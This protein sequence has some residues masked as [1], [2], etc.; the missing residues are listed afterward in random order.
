MHNR[1]AICTICAIIFVYG[2]AGANNMKEKLLLMENILNN[3]G[4]KMKLYDEAMS[5]IKQDDT[6]FQSKI[7]PGFDLHRLYEFL[8]SIEP[9]RL[10][11]TEDHLSCHYCFFRLYVNSS[12]GGG[13]GNYNI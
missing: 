8:R 1:A 6:G 11:F 10:Y 3:F 9:G 4:V 2:G 7:F 5:D 12:T 13:G